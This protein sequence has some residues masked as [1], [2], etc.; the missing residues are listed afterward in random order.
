MAA[1]TLWKEP[2]ELN[3]YAAGCVPGTVS[4]LYRREKYFL[5][6]LIEPRFP[7]RPACSFS[8]YADCASPASGCTFRLYET[9][10]GFHD[11]D[12]FALPVYVGHSSG[13]FCAMT[14]DK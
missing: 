13:P 9:V 6:P 4:S 12:E 5:L 14:F 10:L 11:S 8:H 3:R 1:L 2:Q 7:G